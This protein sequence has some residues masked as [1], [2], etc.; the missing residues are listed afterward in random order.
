MKMD[1]AKHAVNQNNLIAADLER[2]LKALATAPAKAA[3]PTPS[4]KEASPSNNRDGLLGGMLFD[5]LFGFPLTDLLGET[6]EQMTMTENP[7]LSCGTAVDMY[8]EFRRDRAKENRTNGKIELGVQG[9]VN[10]LFNRVGNG[11]LNDA[12]KRLNLE[13]QYAMIARMKRAPGFYMAA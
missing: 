9:S 13:D 2:Q 5:C 8:D 10:G 7:A 6:A 12:P 3:A 4:S 1:F 11:L